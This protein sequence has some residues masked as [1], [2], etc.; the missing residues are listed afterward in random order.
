LGILVAEGCVGSS[1]A[2]RGDTEEFAARFPTIALSSTMIHSPSGDMAA[3]LPAG[4]VALDV[5]HL[6]SPDLFAVACDPEYTVSMI[7]SAAPVDNAARLGFDREGMT[8]LADASFERHRK[9]TSGRARMVGEAE[10]FAIGRRRFGAYTFTTDSMRTLTRVAV[11]YT[12]ANLYECAVTHL[13]FSE[14]ELPSLQK[15]REI[16]QIILSTVEW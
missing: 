5:A 6:E 11:F 7:F 14:T 9:R 13:T 15:L 10:E 2:S 16:H 8:G 1:Q 12:A 3:R 4:W